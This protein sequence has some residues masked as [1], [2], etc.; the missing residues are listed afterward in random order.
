MRKCFRTGRVTQKAQKIAQA[1][2]AK[3]QLLG[4]GLV[5]VQVYRLE[6][7]Q[8]TPPLADHHQ[9]PTTRTVI[10]LILLKM[11]GEMIDTLGEQSNLHVCRTGIALM[12]LKIT[13]RLCLGLHVFH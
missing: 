13:N 10:L 11:L 12:E 8:E 9:Q 6:V 1:L 7:I 3:L 4:H 2:L 5:A